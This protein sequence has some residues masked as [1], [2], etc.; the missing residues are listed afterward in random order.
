M[1]IIERS[2]ELTECLSQ[3]RTQ[4]PLQW[5]R[6]SLWSGVGLNVSLDLEGSR[7]LFE[8]CDL[9]L[10]ESDLGLKPQFML[11]NVIHLNSDFTVIMIA[12]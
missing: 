9:G 2:R 3:L 5:L 6:T 12:D 10:D 8:P 1:F 7:D 4:W 11:K